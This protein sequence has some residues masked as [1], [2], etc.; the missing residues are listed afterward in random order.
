MTHSSALDGN[1][2]EAV[3]LP[4]VS[5]MV[6]EILDDII[7]DVFNEV[8]SN[9]P[10]PV[11]PPPERR[12][13][14]HQLSQDLAVPRIGW[15]HTAK[16][17]VLVTVL[18]CCSNVVFLELLVVQDPGIGNLLTFSQFLVISIEGF[19][20]TTKFG[21][22]RPQ[23]PFAAWLVLVMMYFLVNVIN[24]YAL[25]YNIP[26]PLHMVFRAGSLLVNMLMGMLILG[27]K[28]DRLKYVSVLMISMGI[29]LCTVMSATNRVSLKTGKV[30]F[31]NDTEV[32]EMMEED[33]LHL[34]DMKQLLCGVSLMTISLILSARMGIY[35]EDLFT[36]YGKHAKEALFYTHA[37]PLPLFFFLAPDIV[38]HW[39]VC[40]ASKEVLVPLLDVNIPVMVLH[41]AA[42]VVLQYV[43]IFSVFVLTTECTS[44]TASL[45]L[46][47][48]KFISLLFSIWYFTNP[49]TP[50]HWA[51]TGLVFAGI[52]LFS[53]IPGYLETLRNLSQKKQL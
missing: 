22:L 18:A 49:F 26:M 23:V 51:G 19:V 44:L 38:K 24:N 37:L 29:L 17:A 14:R 50:L 47:T 11:K 27:K 46:T 43:C 32:V 33:G 36:R 30:I 8:S 6:E 4:S 41:L 25:S 13:L 52:L 28:Y 7:D 48:R 10:A 20:F 9:L 42:N 5:A 12:R 1:K 31:Y 15:S 34:E 2:I 45:V 39:R 35:Q 16:L 3:V 21:T 40:L 53:D